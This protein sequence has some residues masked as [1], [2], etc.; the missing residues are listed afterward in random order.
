MKPICAFLTTLLLAPLA[1]LHA[2]DSATAPGDRNHAIVSLRISTHLWMNDARRADLLA[3]L[4]ARRNTIE[5]VAFFTSSTHSVLPYAEIARRARVLAAII[6]EFK[7]LG[8]RVG[9]NHLATLGHTDE[10]LENALNEPWQRITGID[11]RAAK[12]SFC[13]LDPRFQEFTRRCYKALAEAKPDFIWI[14]DDVRMQNHGV[15]L[16]CFCPL[17]LK[18]FGEETG[19]GWTLEQIARSISN[20]D[21]TAAS[22]EVRTK[23]VAHNRRILDELFALIR[24]AVD[25]VNPRLVLGYMPTYLQIYAGMDYARWGQTLAGPTHLPVKWRPGGGFYTDAQPLELLRKAHHVGRNAEAIPPADSDIQ[26]ELESFPYQK[27]KKSETILVAEN[28]AALA[29]GCTG[30]ALNLMGGSPDPFDE[31]LPYFDRIQDA[32]PFFDRLVAQAGRTPC[33]GL[34]PAMTP[35]KIWAA[36]TGPGSAD[37]R[38]CLT[39][40]A[41]IGLPPAYSRAGAKVHLLAGDAVHAFTRS[42]LEKLLSGAVLVDGPALRHLKG[43]G[44]ADLTGFGVA[45]TR[46][47]DAIERFTVD[48]LNGPYSGWWRDCRPAMLGGSTTFLLRPLNAQART[49]AE[50]IDYSGAV[51]G[52]VMGVFENRLGGRIAVLGYYPWTSLQNLSKSAQIK[53]LCRWL[54]RDTLPAYVSSFHKVALWCRRDAA[55]RLVIPLLNASLDTVSGVRL[56]VRGEGP[57]RLSRLNGKEEIVKAA[58]T[59]GAYHVL[60]LHNLSAWEMVVLTSEPQTRRKAAMSTTENG[61][62]NKTKGNK[63]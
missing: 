31:Y 44:L 33:E 17:C 36:G 2:A 39:E 37:P 62:S 3:L 63:P 4:R 7:A 19:E 20:K 45:G 57:F 34:W 28:A 26:Y 6:P 52:P 55:G 10:N 1:A 49:L 18:R 48:Q 43:L 22:R 50:V 5:E 27:L 51:A 25:E 59:D 46:S 58:G 60:E 53:A 38:P 29:A 42:E 12:G 54:S 30:V 40:L 16:S 56:N 9:I 13:P 61:T 8:L 32:K 41:E 21:N 23:W 11:G 47:R 15:G 24:A 35:D 14:D